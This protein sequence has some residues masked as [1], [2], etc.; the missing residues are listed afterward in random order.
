MRKTN[1]KSI[2]AEL[3]FLSRVGDPASVVYSRP[4]R[5]GRACFVA[6]NQR[7]PQ[8]KSALPIENP[9]QTNQRVIRLPQRSVFLFFSPPVSEG[10]LR[11]IKEGFNG[12]QRFN[13]AA[14]ME[15]AV[16]SP[17]RGLIYDS[18]QM[19]RCDDFSVTSAHKCA[20]F[21]RLLSVFLSVFVAQR[22]S[23]DQDNNLRQ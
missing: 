17:K 8:L 18:S 1:K 2:C 9:T 7:S 3:I 16:F 19:S 13:Y 14:E 20:P 15:L 11:E 4:Q 23:P 5:L 10:D 21:K 22:C 6:V 12:A